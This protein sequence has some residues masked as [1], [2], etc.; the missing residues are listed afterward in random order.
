MAVLYG[1]SQWIIPLLLLVIPLWAWWQRVSIYDC[2]VEG[3]AEG[4]KTAI[5]IFPYILG[6]LVA[7]GIFRSSGA[8]EAM[9]VALSP[10][11]DWIG[12]PAEVL[13]LAMIRPLSGSG[14]LGVTA[15]LINTYGP[16]SFI[17]HLASM[18]QGS[19]DTTFYILAVYFGAVGIKKYRHAVWV[20]L[21]ADCAGFLAAIF[22][23]HLFF[24][25]S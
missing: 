22:M 21:T 19:T 4:I 3:A 24:P 1:V 20:G 5:R 16:D 18:M 8:L 14:A 10:V 7:I 23:C 2:F 6:M 17:G 15:E 9:V 13:P 11:L 12:F 25:G